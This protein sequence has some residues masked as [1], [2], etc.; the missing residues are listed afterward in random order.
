MTKGTFK[1]ER[2]SWIMQGSS[3]ITGAFEGTELSRVS[4][5]RSHERR[6]S[7]WQQERSTNPHCWRDPCREQGRGVQAA[8]G[9][10]DRAP[11]MTSKKV[12]AQSTSRGAK[13]YPEADSAPEYPGKNPAGPPPGET[14]S[15]GPRYCAQ[16]SHHRAVT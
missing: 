16:T 2:L 6:R 12:G 8:S 10:K 14:V 3:L 15:K 13:L 7:Y 4:L 11:L 5:E 1:T 9:G